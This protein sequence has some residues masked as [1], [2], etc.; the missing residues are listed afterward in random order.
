VRDYV[1]FTDGRST[2]RLVDLV[3]SVVNGIS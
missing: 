1:H 3:R 2:D